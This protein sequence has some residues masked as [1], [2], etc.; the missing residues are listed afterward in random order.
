MRGDG[1]DRWNKPSNRC[2]VCTS[3]YVYTRFLVR[4][5]LGVS[6]NFSSDFLLP[7]DVSISWT[8]IGL[9]PRSIV[10]GPAISHDLAQ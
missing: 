7:P 1:I 4:L 10:S 9:G 8:S 5:S 6:R 3:E 2:E